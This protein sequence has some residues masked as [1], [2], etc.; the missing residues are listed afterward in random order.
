MRWCNLFK[1]FADGTAT[2]KEINIMMMVVQ[3]LK[4]QTFA[5]KLPELVV[6]NLFNFDSSLPGS[7]LSDSLAHDGFI[8]NLAI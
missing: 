4:F 5:G 8:S 3:W 1:D 7:K 2:A 6:I